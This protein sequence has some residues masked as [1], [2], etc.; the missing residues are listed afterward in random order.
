M[1]DDA[2]IVVLEK[3]AVDG[4]YAL[5]VGDGYLAAASNS[6]NYVV[7]TT[8]LDDNASWMITIGSDAL[9]TIKAQ[10]DKTRNTLQYNTSSPRFSCYKSGQKPVNIYAKSPVTTDIEDIDEER[11]TVDVYTI[12]GIVVRKGVDPSDALQGLQRGIYIVGGKKCF[13]K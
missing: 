4:T 1:A 7:T 2:Q 12:T 8:T 3:G 5:N 9:A 13:I 6:S 11:N 10:G